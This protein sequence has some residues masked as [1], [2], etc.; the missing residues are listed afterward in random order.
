MSTSET[1][2]AETSG[3][4]A[5]F[6]IVSASQLR[7][8][9]RLNFPIH[10]SRN[11]LLLGQ[12]QTITVTFLRHLQ[13]RGITSI[14]MHTSE[15]ARLCAGEPQGTMKK[16]RADRQG[17]LVTLRNDT[18]DRL[19]HEIDKQGVE[20]P[21][22]GIP[23]SKQFQR[24]PAGNFSGKLKDEVVERR[25]AEV[26]QVSTIFES[27]VRGRSLDVDKMLAVTEATF[28][29]I[30]KDIDLVAVIGVNPF[31]NP[32]PGRHCVHSSVLATIIGT[33]LNL[34][35]QTLQELA[36][37][38]LL[39]DAG[40][41][42]VSRSTFATRNPLTPT[43]FEEIAKHPI[44]LFDMLKDIKNIPPRSAMVCYQLH[45]RCNGTGYP[46]RQPGSGIHY[47]SKIAAVADAYVGLVSPRPHRRALIPYFAMV[48]ML[49]GV[50]QGLYDGGVVRAM[51]NALSLFPLGSYLR[52]SDGRVGRVIRANP[53]NY[54][55]PMLEVWPN[56]ELGTAPDL[57]EL[58]NSELQVVS[59]MA[60]LKNA[61]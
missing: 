59:P 32:Y 42:K 51:L 34:D 14:R 11:I 4:L 12:G 28:A 10:D 33:S 35:R 39:H 44:V 13:S 1:P 52:L 61:A 43:E 57:L 48:A 17:I 23:F 49:E 41:L 46:R 5:E 19:D 9:A 55:R 30:A 29:D 31:F 47:L 45:E 36:L 7:I 18:T 50:R 16:A 56:D 40:M 25:C 15:L 38:C 37:G 22:Q 26:E 53:A 2:A 60:S 21:T 3:Q 6:Q 8:G 58:Q 54:T 24:P 27:L 20:L